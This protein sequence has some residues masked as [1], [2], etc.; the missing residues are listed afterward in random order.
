[1]KLISCHISG[2]GNL[3]NRDIAF[4]DGLTQ[5]CEPNG[6]GKTTLASFIKAMFYGLPAYRKGGEEDSE[7]ARYYPFGRGAFGGSL[8]FEKDGAV[9]RIERGFGEK[10]DKDDYLKVYKNDRECDDFGADVGKKIFGMDRESFERTVFIDSRATEMYATA[11]MSEKL[12]GYADATEG[13]NTFEHAMKRLEDY[14]KSFKAARG[15]GGLINSERENIRD[16][17]DRIHNLESEEATLTGKYGRSKEL[18]SEINALTA[19]LTEAG[20]ANA[21]AEQWNNYDGMLRSIRETEEELAR[22]A[23]AYPGGIPTNDDIAEARRL[24]DRLKELSVGRETR[25]FG[26]EDA[27]RLAAYSREFGRGVPSEEELAAV[28]DDI[29]RYS[30][31]SAAPAAPAPD[32]RE[33]RLTSRF[34]NMD[35]ESAERARAAAAR[36]AEL[37]RRIKSAVVSSAP[38]AAPVKRKT[39]FLIAAI[40]LGIVALGGIGV[41]FALLPAGIAMLIAG[42]LGCGTCGIIYGVSGTPRA[43][44]PAAAPDAA[45]REEYDA[46]RNEVYDFLMLLGYTPSGSE[47]AD[48]ALYERDYE[49]YGRLRARRIEL[50]RGDEERKAKLAGAAKRLDDF[51][52]KYGLCEG[53]YMQRRTR[54]GADISGYESL[55]AARERSEESAGKLADEETAVRGRL[56]ALF[57]KYGLGENTDTDALRRDRT[58]ADERARDIGKMKRRAEEFRTENGLTERPAGGKKDISALESRRSALEREATSVDREIAEIEDRVAALDACRAE[59]A[60]ANERLA[61][62]KRGY[63]VALKARELL[64]AAEKNLRDRYVAPVREKFGYYASVLEDTFGEKASI[65][66]DFRVK[67]ES[68]GILRSDMHL[69]AGQRAVCSLCFRLAMTDNMFAGETPFVIMDDPFV[70]LDNAHMESAAKAIRLLSRDRQIVYLCCHDSRKAE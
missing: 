2:Y 51:F 41:C 26:E 45:L 46:K 34:V 33:R 54:L 60:D 17:T 29:S 9:Y 70:D 50:A 67:F 11:G 4:G 40:A 38:V 7:R 15:S 18:R 6:F 66:G 55:R 23:A 63:D 10:S 43:D 65:D 58:A 44:I 32:E 3:R 64:G 57:G 37:D 47:A 24:K 62:Y 21:V 14:A 22:T 48:F 16:L 25:R 1:M 8:T 53:S 31:L 20:K 49:E 13:K 42:A 68:D 39:P 27:R 69:S 61:G 30:A 52:A 56:R 5:I 19:E 28:D 59:L 12:G 35:A 36:C